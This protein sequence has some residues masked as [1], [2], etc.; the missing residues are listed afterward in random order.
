MSDENDT[1]Q[2]SPEHGRGK[3]PRRRP[4]T[5]LAAFGIAAVAILAIGAAGGAAAMKFTR[6]NVELAPL[7]PVSISSL[8]DDLSVVTVKGKVAEIFGNK[9]IVQDDSGRALIETGPAGDD[10]KLVSIGETVSVQGR[11]DHGFLHASYI[12]H[13][14]GKTDVLRS[15]PRRP[16]HGGPIEDF[17]KRLRP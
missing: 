8:N 2:V 7:T 6:P 17:L 5:H 11:F 10:S 14:D 9:F 3:G 13:Q 1:S 4:A 12:V 15:P 16:P